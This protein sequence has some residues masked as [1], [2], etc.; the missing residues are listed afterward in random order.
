MLTFTRHFR[1]WG[2]P[3]LSMVASHPIYGH[4]RFQICD[5]YFETLSFFCSDIG[6][7]FLMKRRNV[8]HEKW[9]VNFFSLSSLQ[10]QILYF[11]NHCYYRNTSKSFTPFL[12][13]ISN[14]SPPCLVWVEKQCL[15]NTH[16]KVKKQNKLCP[17]QAMILWQTITK[18]PIDNNLE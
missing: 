6:E 16:H 15:L 14:L 1:P 10:K 3:V 11:P 9:C 18:Q 2:S 5:H 12:Q 8:K 17:F 4:Q 7:M 13:P